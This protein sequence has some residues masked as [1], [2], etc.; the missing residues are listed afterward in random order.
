MNKKRLS[1]SSKLEL[2][3]VTNGRLC[4]LIFHRGSLSSLARRSREAKAA[5]CRSKADLSASGGDPARGP[6]SLLALSSSKGSKGHLSSGLDVP[7]FHSGVS[8]NSIFILPDRT[9]SM[10]IL[11]RFRYSSPN[12]LSITSSS[13]NLAVI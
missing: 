13:N 9:S 11:S 3:T 6:L 12:S 7:Y 10:V 8:V 2:F 5:A 1:M 4:L